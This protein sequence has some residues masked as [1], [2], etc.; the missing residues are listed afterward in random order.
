MDYPTGEIPI[1][2]NLAVLF[3]LA[4]IV[5]SII[6][7][8]YN[9]LILFSMLFYFA[10]IVLVL[11]FLTVGSAIIAERYTYIPYI[12]IAFMIGYGYQYYSILYI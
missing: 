12:G 7:I 11:Q 5:L 1:I 3:S 4:I 8:K 9:R 2:Y 10:N 6:S